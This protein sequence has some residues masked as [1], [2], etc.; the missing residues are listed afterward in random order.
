M[1]QCQGRPEQWMCPSGRK[2]WRSVPDRGGVSWSPGG[3]DWNGRR[4][5][6]LSQGALPGES[7]GRALVGGSV[8]LIREPSV[9]LAIP[10]VGGILPVTKG[11][12]ARCRIP[13]VFTN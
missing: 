12:S 11:G 10:R 2:P 8:A 1:P 5:K 7:K 6:G 4:V 9:C 13:E 3:V